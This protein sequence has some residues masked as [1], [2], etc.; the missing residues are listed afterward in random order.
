MWIFAAKRAVQTIFL[1]CIFSLFIFIMI[2][3][4]SG[5]IVSGLYGDNI[6]ALNPALKERILAN[7][8][9]DRPL[10]VRYFEWF[11]NFIRGDFGF[12]FI[13][14]EKV[15]DI[16]KD[17]LPY[18]LILGTISFFLSFV[19]A[20]I[21]GGLSA[22][23]QGSLF[24]KIVMIIT[25]SF[26]SVP[27]F[28]LSLIFIMFFSVILGIFPSSGAYDIGTQGNFIDLAHHMILP[29]L[30]LSLSHLA[31]YIRLVRTTVLEALKEPFVTSYRSW[32]VDKKDIYLKL[33][34]RYSLLPV[35]SY[36]SANSAVIL[37]GT[38]VVETVFSIGGLGNTTINALLD[39]DYPLALIIIL[40]STIFVVFINLIVEI[41]AKILN[42][43]F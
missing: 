39:K 9:L 15:I 41:S 29:I 11:L 8:G 34:L 10:M 2:E 14:G 43:R 31:I 28:W 20:V 22:I 27:S 30:V 25:L 6:Q 32:G 17:R 24:D 21:L 5:N 33:V 38:Y 4:S 37:S 16:I 23:F 18:T 42:P 7:L 36:F 35:I 1:I 19:L 26:F 40:L 13:S 3:F 12:S